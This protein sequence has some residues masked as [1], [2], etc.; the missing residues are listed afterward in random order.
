M[1]I[2]LRSPIAQLVG[3]ARGRVLDTLA[4]VG[5][6]FSIRQIAEMSDVHHTQASE[7]L[8]EFEGMGLVR[9]Q[10]VGRSIAYEPVEGNILLAAVRRVL[11][12]RTEILDGLRGGAEDAPSGVTLAVFGSV[13]SGRAVEGSDL[14]LAVITEDDAGS[15]T[16]K[17]V[18]QYI[19]FARAAT[20]MEVS[21]LRYTQSQWSQAKAHGELITKTIADNHVL[22]TG[23][24]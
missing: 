19:T 21:P 12:L 13:A 11:L 24:L 3:G 10:R 20:G 8:R 16:N 15:D 4:R 2:N 9:S 14:D 18:E 1:P 6:A 23:K 7:L 5:R 17:W 22:L